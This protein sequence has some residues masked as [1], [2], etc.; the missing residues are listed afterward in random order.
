MLIDKLNYL[1]FKDADA[2]APGGLMNALQLTNKFE[3]FTKM[4]KQSGILFYVPAWNT[5][6]IDPLTGFVDLLKPKYENINAS[7]D[8]FGNFDVIRYNETKNYFEFGFDY[9]K[10]GNK[11]EDT[12]T[13]WTVCTFGKERY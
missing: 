6:K 5:S 11:A 2:Q 10:F 13:K 7:K 8:F 9:N 1:V 4:G 12:Q 3:S